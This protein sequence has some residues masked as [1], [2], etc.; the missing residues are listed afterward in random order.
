MIDLDNEEIEKYRIEK[1]GN[2]T[3][4]LEIIK[5]YLYKESNYIDIDYPDFDIFKKAIENIINEKPKNYI[6]LDKIKILKCLNCGAL[7]YDKRKNEIQG[8]H[9]I[10]D[11]AMLNEVIKGERKINKKEILSKIYFIEEQLEKLKELLES[12]E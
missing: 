4:D 10:S 11:N 7:L 5:D 8:L 12:E 3:T 9:I 1:F 6:D 2:N